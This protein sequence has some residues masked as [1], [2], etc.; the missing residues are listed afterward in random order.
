MELGFDESYVR[1]VCYA[2]A[3][4][5]LFVGGIYWRRSAVNQ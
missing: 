5:P 4:M 2:I 1:R 3:Y